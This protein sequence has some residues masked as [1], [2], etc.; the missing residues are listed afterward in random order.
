MTQAD[1]AAALVIE[2]GLARADDIVAVSPMTGGVASDIS[3]VDLGDRRICT[4]FALAKLKVA[5]DWRAPLSRNRAEYAWLGFAGRVEPSAVPRLLGRSEAAKGFAMDCI[6]GPDVINWKQALM[7]GGG[8]DGHAARV[9]DRL[10]QLHTASVQ[11]GFDRT[12]FDNGADFVA[13]R[14]EPYL[15]FTASRLPQV[16]EPLHA[17]SAELRRASVVL[18][19]GDVSPKNILFRGTTPIFL[20]AE[21]A[22]MGDP[23]FDLAFCLN[24][25]LLKAIHFPDRADRLTGAAQA[26]WAAYRPAIG[27]EAPNALERRAARLLPALMLARVR[28]KSPVEYL[29]PTEQARVIDLAVPMLLEP[30]DR[31]A[32]VFDGVRAGGGGGR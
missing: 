13:L 4:K 6:D 10:G 28:G 30:P 12:G 9:G 31:L 3:V 29:S 2:L 26:L 32:G 18:I 5:E 17:L 8:C 11:P 19:H 14:L 22:T 7:T 23:V 15:D 27:W 20:D 25:L 16:A 1:R 21:C 24:H